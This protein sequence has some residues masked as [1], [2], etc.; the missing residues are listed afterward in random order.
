VTK[1]AGPQPAGLS[2][3]LLG[4]LVSAFTEIEGAR[5]FEKAAAGPVPGIDQANLFYRE[6][7]R[8][9]ERKEL[10]EF[11]SCFQGAA[12]EILQ[13]VKHS[14]MESEVAKV[15]ALAQQPTV[16]GKQK[17]KPQTELDFPRFVTLFEG[18]L[19]GKTGIAAQITAKGAPAV[20][21]SKFEITYLH[22]GAIRPDTKE[23]TKLWEL[24]TTNTS[25]LPAVTPKA[26]LYK[27]IYEWLHALGAQPFIWELGKSQFRFSAD[28]V[29]TFGKTRRTQIAGKVPKKI[30]YL[31]DAPQGG[32]G[33]RIG[34]HAGQKGEKRES[35]HT[36]QYLL[37]QFFRNDNKVKA[38]QSGRN[39]PGINAQRT[40][41]KADGG[42]TLGLQNLDS[43]NSKRGADMPAILIAADTHRRGQLHIERETQ[44]SGSG[45]N[46]D[47][48]PGQGRATQGFAIKGQFQRR[49]KAEFKVTDEN[50]T[51]WNKTIASVGNDAAARGIGKAMLGT[52]QWMHGIMMPAL[53][54]ALITRERAYYNALA[55]RDGHTLASGRLDPD[56]ALTADD[57]KS[58]Y[59]KALNN[60]NTIMGA[61]G[62][63]LS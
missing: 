6:F 51:E 31:D 47:S 63:T 20:A 22:F 28:F 23:A 24:V 27:E 13:Y 29:E 62:W 3:E 33:L 39:Y 16:T 56:Y 53:E 43:D 45:D 50:A 10:V 32:V 42:T 12:V 15:A 34:K 48:D 54:R 57:M 8:R 35:H 17:R 5:E 18:A 2:P 1:A 41:F 38:W 58:V 37:I 61:A 55:A 44:W 14:G 9:L 7:L 40:E 30:E 49:L 59:G 21:I 60:N 46:P 11:P 19:F 26:N 36:T 25:G 52:Y 4:K